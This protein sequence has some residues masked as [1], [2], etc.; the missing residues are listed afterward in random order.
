[1]T[2]SK[3]F[4]KYNEVLKWRLTMSEDWVHYCVRQAIKVFIFVVYSARP[5]TIT[6]DV[7]DLF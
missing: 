6:S 5:W 1:M 3:D 4:I 7:L 2:S